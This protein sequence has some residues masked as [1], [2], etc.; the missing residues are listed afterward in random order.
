MATKTLL[1]RLSFR[2]FPAPTKAP[3][4]SLLIRF[5]EGRAEPAIRKFA[6]D[7]IPI[8]LYKFPDMKV[9]QA[10]AAAGE[11]SLITLVETGGAARTVTITG[12]TERILYAEVT[13]LTET[14]IEAPLPLIVKHK[15][16]LKRRKAA[17]KAE[18]SPAKE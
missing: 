11:A 12:K 8:L 14:D 15:S 2:A 5:A 17:A 1:G 16:S 6:R 18:E 7:F 13:G 3:C 4:E 10:R 9:T